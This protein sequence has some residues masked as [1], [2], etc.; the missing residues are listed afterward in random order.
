MMEARKW[1]GRARSI[2]REIDALRAAK[3][4]AWD[5]LTKITQNYNSDGAQSS[6]DPHKHDR[7]AELEDQIDRKI[8]ELMLTKAEILMVIGKI[9]DGR[10]R[11]ILCDYYI[12]GMTLEQIAVEISYSYAHVKRLRAEGIADVQ[13][14]KL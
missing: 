6:P 8:R 4:E 7:I 13:K 11:T 1:L 3:Q 10:K 2:N 12:R 9:Q 14:M 5:Q